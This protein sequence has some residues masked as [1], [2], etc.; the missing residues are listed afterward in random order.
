MDQVAHWL[1]RE[2]GRP[3]PKLNAHGIGDRRVGDFP[4]VAKVVIG[5]T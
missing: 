1:L 3:F 4:D 2:S 5:F